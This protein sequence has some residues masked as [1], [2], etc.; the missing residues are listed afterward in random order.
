MMDDDWI[1]DDYE[2]ELWQDGCPVAK[3]SAKNRDAALCE[4]G[5]YAMVYSQDG[6]V[7][8]YEVKRTKVGYRAA[9]AMAKETE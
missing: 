9:A 4:I 6:P 3:A 7:S 2:F 1:T 8:V 5:H